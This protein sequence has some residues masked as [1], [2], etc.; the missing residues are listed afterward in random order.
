M[1]GKSFSKFFGKNNRNVF[2]VIACLF[3]PL[4]LSVKEGFASS[5]L[6]L[7]KG[8]E[9]YDN[10]MKEYKELKKESDSV[11]QKAKDNTQNIDETNKKMKTFQNDT[12]NE[13]R[14]AAT[15]YANIQQRIEKKDNEEELEGNITQ[16]F[17]KKVSTDPQM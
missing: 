7:F 6:K 15:E 17:G 16:I 13:V 1:I 5:G 3:V 9:Y 11:T 12:M 14:N 8:E 4:L 2:I 10:K